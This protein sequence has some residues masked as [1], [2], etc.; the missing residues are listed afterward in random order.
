MG[1]SDYM[2]LSLSQLS[3]SL[4][5]CHQ[6]KKNNSLS[7]HPL[8]PSLFTLI[9]LFLILYSASISNLY[10]HSRHHHRTIFSLHG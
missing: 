5:V 10:R 1:P 2:H 9:S 3:L 7:V 6:E 4:S 8:P